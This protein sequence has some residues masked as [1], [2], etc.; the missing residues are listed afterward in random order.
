[1]IF[2][3]V[4]VQSTTVNAPKVGSTAAAAVLT[5]MLDDF[6]V[7]SRMSATAASIRVR[8]SLQGKSDDIVCVVLRGSGEVVLNSLLHHQGAETYVLVVAGYG[9]GDCLFLLHLCTPRE[10]PERDH[11]SAKSRRKGAVLSICGFAPKC[12]LEALAIAGR[13]MAA[14]IS[15][16]TADFMACA[17]GRSARP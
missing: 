14:Q 17:P 5:L 6:F 4:D 9:R 16:S 15:N 7:P 8:V 13:Q 2:R 12:N 1:M 10:R 3:L 11:Y